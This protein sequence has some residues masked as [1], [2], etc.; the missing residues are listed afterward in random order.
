VHVNSLLLDSKI[1]DQ[2]IVGSVAEMV[3]G[4]LNPNFLN[5]TINREIFWL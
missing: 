1:C 4:A 2:F 3:K 5:L